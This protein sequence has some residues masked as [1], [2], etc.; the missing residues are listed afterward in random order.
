M[1]EKNYTVKKFRRIVC[2]GS[3]GLMTDLIS[4]GTG[5]TFAY[6]SVL[7][8]GYAAPFNI[9]GCDT[10]RDFIFVYLDTPDAANAA[11]TFINISARYNKNL[12][13]NSAVSSD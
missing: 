13:D 7:G 11:E 9:S 3:F 12:R 8:S 10:F 4:K 2:I 6:K 5:I 1:E